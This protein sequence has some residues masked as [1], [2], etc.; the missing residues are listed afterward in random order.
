[1]GG[2]SMKD[3]KIK[4]NIVNL[5]QS[6]EHLKNLCQK[7]DNSVAELTMKFEVLVEILEEKENAE[8][9]EEN[10]EA[11]GILNEV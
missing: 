3:Y 7:L 2:G 10:E 11:E 9:E 4:E 5:R 1:V 6:I 8:K